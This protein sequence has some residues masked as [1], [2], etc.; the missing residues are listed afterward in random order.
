MGWHVYSQSTIFNPWRPS[1]LLIL[2]S[3]TIKGHYRNSMNYINFSMA[4]L[5][6]HLLP[7]SSLFHPPSPNPINF[8][9]YSQQNTSQFNT[10][11]H[12]HKDLSLFCKKSPMQ[13]F[14]QRGHAMW[15]GEIGSQ[16]YQSIPSERV[17]KCLYLA[18]GCQ[19]LWII[20][21]STYH[22]LYHF[23]LL[24]C[25]HIDSPVNANNSITNPI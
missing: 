14:V 12:T 1:Q 22:V 18:L 20:S 2:I 23:S 11:T 17:C 15:F 8:Q 6:F 16:C 13:K 25:V 4:C 9:S 7:M 5:I 19:I 3:S 24:V 10:Y 21:V